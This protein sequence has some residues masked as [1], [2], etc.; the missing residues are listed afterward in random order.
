[1]L[2]QD[3]NPMINL[4]LAINMHM[5]IILYEG[6]VHT[7]AKPSRHNALE[8]TYAVQPVCHK[9]QDNIRTYE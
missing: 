8:K 1:M 5:E 3:V 6:C 4:A 7:Y 2:I 9:S